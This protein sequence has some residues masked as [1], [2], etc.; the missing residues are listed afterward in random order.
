MSLCET[1]DS[2]TGHMGY[3][4]M[5]ILLTFLL[6]AAASE[7][8][9]LEKISCRELRGGTGSQRVLCA[10]HWKLGAAD[11]YFLS[12]R[13]ESRRAADGRVTQLKEEIILFLPINKGDP[14]FV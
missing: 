13:D 5:H 12:L 10:E 3:K 11:K 8:S 6:L 14:R 2:L 1:D 4:V 7:S 9:H